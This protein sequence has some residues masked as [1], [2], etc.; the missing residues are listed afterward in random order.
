ME[1]ILADCLFNCTSVEKEHSTFKRQFS[2]VFPNKVVSRVLVDLIYAILNGA[3][4]K[5]RYDY[6]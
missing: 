3:R 6:A 1:L 4:F 5:A 2:L